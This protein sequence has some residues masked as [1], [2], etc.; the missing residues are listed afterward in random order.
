MSLIY[1]YRINGKL[2]KFETEQKDI[3][4]HEVRFCK[5][6]WEI[7]LRKL[8]VSNQKYSTYAI[9]PPEKPECYFTF[10]S[11]KIIISQ[12]G[13]MKVK[14]NDKEKVLNGK[15]FEKIILEN[16]IIPK[17]VNLRSLIY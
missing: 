3:P 7:S 14:G 8:F 6:Y 9:P 13:N 12:T 17:K 11:C 15:Y 10:D 4:I 2:A 5:R 16:Q 1:V